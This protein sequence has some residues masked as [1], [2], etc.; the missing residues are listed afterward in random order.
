MSPT[1]WRSSKSSWIKRNSLA[2]RTVSLHSSPYSFE[3]SNVSY[4]RLKRRFQTAQEDV[5]YT[6]LAL[7]PTLAEQIMEGMDVESLTQELQARSKA[8]TTTGLQH[9][10]RQQNEANPG[11]DDEGHS[12]SKPNAATQHERDGTQRS[13]GSSMV[14]VDLEVRSE[15]GSTASAS[16]VDASSRDGESSDINSW[17]EASTSGRSPRPLSGDSSSYHI[18]NEHQLSDSVL[19]EGSVGNESKLASHSCITLRALFTVGSSS[20]IA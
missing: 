4:Y 13:L 12:H 19:T 3:L 5:S 15:A 2:K 18:P 6:V 17:M 1:G 8:R 20:P 7:L 16:F 14:H 11:R 10:I 9:T